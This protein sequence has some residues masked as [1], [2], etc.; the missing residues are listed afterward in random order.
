VTEKVYTFEEYLALRK[1]KKVS[2]YLSDQYE[3]TYM[4]KGPNMLKEPVRT[5]LY[6]TEGK[7]EHDRVIARWLKD[8][9]NGEFVEVS[10]S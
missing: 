5:Q 8:F 3:V 6:V 4:I 7:N 2:P 9:P 1:K 10:Y